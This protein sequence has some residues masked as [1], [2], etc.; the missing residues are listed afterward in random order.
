MQNEEVIKKELLKDWEEICKVVRV[1][2]ERNGH[3]IVIVS[4]D[5]K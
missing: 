4:K 5:S 2:L 3:D 1:V